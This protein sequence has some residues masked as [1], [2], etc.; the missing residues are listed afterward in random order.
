MR[1][2]TEITIGSTII[3]KSG[4]R[5]K[6]DRVDGGIIYSGNLRVK[7]SAVVKVEPPSLGDR[8]EIIT[9]LDNPEAIEQLSILLD[10][11]GD[12]AIYRTSLNL[13]SFPGTF[14]RRLLTSLHDEGEP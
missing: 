14:I 12:D 1:A 8:L 4:K 5:L 11:A 2:M 6:V 3:G 10:E 9:T 7:L 13:D